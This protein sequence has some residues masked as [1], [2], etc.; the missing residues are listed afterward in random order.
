MSEPY[1]SDK[2]APLILDGL[3]DCAIYAMDVHGRV[4]SWNVGAERLTGYSADEVIGRSAA[5][6]LVSGAGDEAELRRHLTGAEREQ[7]VT[8][9]GWRLRKD[10]TRFWADG[11]LVTLRDAEDVIIGFTHVLRDRTEEKE[12]EEVLRTSEAMFQGI[13][14]IATDAVVCVDETQRITFFNQGAERIFGYSTGEVL[15]APLELLVPERSRAGHAQEVE[16]FGRSPV[17]S[18]RMGERGEISG[19]RKDGEIFPAEASISKLTVGRRQIFT[20]VVRDI[21]ERRAAEEALAR[22]ATDLA[23]SNA[24]L[25]Q[26][27]YVASHDLQEPLRMV[28][29]YTQLL[30]RRY[31]DKLDDDALEFIG[32][33]VDGV[34]RMQS[35][36]ND[37]LAYSRVGTRGG[38]FEEVDADALFRRVL[39]GLGP[40]I[41]EA[42]A[43]VSADALPTLSADAGQLGQLLQNLVANAVKFRGESAPHVHVSARRDADAWHFSVADNGIGISPEYAERIFVIFQR[44]HTRD[45]YPG[46]GIGLAICK[47]IVERHGGRIWF[48]STPGEGTT[49]HFT[50]PDAG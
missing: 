40:A 17:A 31:R 38:A 26:F 30:A 1:A 10:G 23:R 15:G 14:A 13:L 7:S 5:R 43:T 22:Q 32:Y 27:A 11:T 46:T 19:R 3:R 2:I 29:S 34:N 24:E 44:L 42:G 21:S 48:E 41:E 37:L 49:F 39:A 6:L 28:A 45:R 9:C 25:E 50:I 8:E 35:L 20:A 36:I 12:R 33:A 47:K 18:R 4:M 16:G